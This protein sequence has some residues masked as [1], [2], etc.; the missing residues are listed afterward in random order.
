[1]TEEEL[2]HSAK[3]AQSTR[4]K[5]SIKNNTPWKIPRPLIGISDPEKLGNSGKRT[6]AK[7]A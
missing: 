2:L 6:G 1:M 4:L 7:C 3:P 5:K